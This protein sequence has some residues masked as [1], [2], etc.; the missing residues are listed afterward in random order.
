MR[1][2]NGLSW[3]RKAMI[4]CGLAL[5]LNGIWDADQLSPD[6]RTILQKYPDELAG[7][8]RSNS[9]RSAAGDSSS[10]DDMDLIKKYSSSANGLKANLAEVSSRCRHDANARSYST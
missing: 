1:D 9:D 7:A 2:E 3:S 10:D 5:D 6:F 4:R 8:E